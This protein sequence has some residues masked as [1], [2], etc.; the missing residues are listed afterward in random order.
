MRRP[1]VAQRVALS[2]GLAG[3]LAAGLVLAAATSA[4]AHV[5]LDPSTTEAGAHA[6]VT[7]AVPHGCEGSGTTELSIRMPEGVSDLEVAES[8]GWSASAAVDGVTFHADEPVPDHEHATVE[9]S[10]RLPDEPGEVL[11]FPVVQ[12]CDV[13]EEAW[14]EVAEDDASREALARPAPLIVV[15]GTPAASDSPVTDPTAEVDA[16]AQ[17]DS[18]AQADSPAQTDS[19]PQADSPAKPDSA[20]QTDSRAATAT[21]EAPS[22]ES[23]REASAAAIEEAPA[24][25]APVWALA[26][27]A[28]VV[29]GAAAGLL[30]LIRRRRS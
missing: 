2:G 19:A 24:D 14:T 15:T 23:T 4:A 11:V 28:L 27:G 22:A 20:P 10:I 18:V 1:Q 3:L 13:G 6:R 30:L 7:V 25:G 12:R 26:A 29:G 9:F 17:T 5:T 16:P 8:D 21:V